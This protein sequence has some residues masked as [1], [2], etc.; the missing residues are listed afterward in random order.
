MV[1]EV[2]F[3]GHFLPGPMA[4][5]W[6][7]FWPNSLLP[8]GM[9]LAGSIFFS[10]FLISYLFT[11]I[12]ML[13]GRRH[14]SIASAPV[15][16]D[17]VTKI[18]ITVAVNVVTVLLIL[19]HGVVAFRN[20]RLQSKVFAFAALA[21]TILSNIELVMTKLG[22]DTRIGH[23]YP[24]C[25]IMLT[26]LINPENMRVRYFVLAFLLVVGIVVAA[27]FAAMA[28]TANIVLMAAINLVGGT[29]LIATVREGRFQELDQFVTIA[30]TVVQREKAKNLFLSV[31]PAHVGDKLL[32]ASGDD[33]AP[34]FCDT[35][36]NSTV[37][38]IMI[39][40]PRTT[41]H[42]TDAAGAV[43]SVTAI[44]AAI[45]R[46]L[47]RARSEVLVKTAHGSQW[48]PAGDRGKGAAPQCDAA[49]V[50]NSATFFLMM[51]WLSM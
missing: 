14:R 51:W 19:F 20:R 48:Q 38:Y 1:V 29:I 26:M 42:G 43:S 49:K 45:D 11:R 30:E 5:A 37:M 41:S 32:G 21:A 39:D 8:R 18:L 27:V 4:D 7:V 46:G 22:T 13:L 34:N 47:L 40:L 35:H 23:C 24:C 36:V 44:C 16:T 6:N 33:E 28:N 50:E 9:D 25:L 2:D 3:F 31:V 10:F 17:I 12:L 15:T